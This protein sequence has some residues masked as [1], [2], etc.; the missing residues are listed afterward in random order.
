M[1]GTIDILRDRAE[2]LR[3]EKGLCLED[4]RDMAKRIR[5]INDELEDIGEKIQAKK[6]NRWERWR[7]GV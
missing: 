6:G 1:R 3:H 7:L 4:I 5:E 2:S